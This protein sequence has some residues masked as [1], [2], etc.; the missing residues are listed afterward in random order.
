MVELNSKIAID[1]NENRSHSTLS[2][3]NYKEEH[4]K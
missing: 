3:R 1:N 2:L 4:S